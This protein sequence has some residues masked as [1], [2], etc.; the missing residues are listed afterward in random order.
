MVSIFRE[1]IGRVIFDDDGDG[2]P[3]RMADKTGTNRPKN[4]EW[5]KV[6]REKGE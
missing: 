5:E 3:D 6:E 2:V 4:I 1:K